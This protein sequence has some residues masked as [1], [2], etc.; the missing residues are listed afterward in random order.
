MAGAKA[1]IPSVRAFAA[2]LKEAAEKGQTI[3][4]SGYQ[5]QQGLKAHDDFEAVAARLKSC[6]VTKRETE[7]V[8]PQ[9]LKSCPV[10]EQKRWNLRRSTPGARS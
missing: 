10:T 5:A 3:G 1:Q 7:R 2:T 9:S 4:E 6:P 8:F